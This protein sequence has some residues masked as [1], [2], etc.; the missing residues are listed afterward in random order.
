MSATILADAIHGRNRERLFD[1]LPAL[2]MMDFRV[3]RERKDLSRR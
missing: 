1:A 2:K 3:N